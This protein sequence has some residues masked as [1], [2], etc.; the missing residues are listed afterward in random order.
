MIL[1]RTTD[2]AGTDSAIALRGNAILDTGDVGPY[3]ALSVGLWVRAIRPEA[4]KPLRLFWLRGSDA[5]TDLWLELRDQVSPAG[6]VQAFSNGLLGY[7]SL[8]DQ[9]VDQ[10]VWHHIVLSVEPG[11]AHLM[12]DGLKQW[13]SAPVMAGPWGGEALL[14]MVGEF[15]EIARGDIADLRIWDRFLSERTVAAA[16]ADMVDN[17]GMNTYPWELPL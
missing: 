1:I 5:S 3:S 7:Q 9:F 8:G 11:R 2:P 12:V 14:A 16:Y 13:T 4:D 17:Q 6:Y 10:S 15:P